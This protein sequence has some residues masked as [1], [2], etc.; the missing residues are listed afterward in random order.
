ML[1]AAAVLLGGA[2]GEADGAE[3]LV[4]LDFEDAADLRL[5]RSRH[6]TGVSDAISSRGRSS[7]RVRT[8]DTLNVVTPRLGGARP[9]DLLKLD[10][11]NATAAPRQVRVEL[12]DAQSAKGYWHR[13]VRRYALRP[14]WNT[15]RF[16][17][18]RLYRGEKN[19]R[20][21]HDTY[22]DPSHI[23]RLDLSLAAG[24]E[25]GSVYLDNLRFE[26]D[27]PMPPVDGLLAFD[28]GPENQAPR[29]GFIACSRERY[30][31]DR[32]YGWKTS[33]WP[34]AVRD[35]VHP[36]DLLGDVREAR[37]DTFSVRV[38]NGTYHVRVYYEDHGWWSD[39]FARFSRRTL[40]AEGKPAYEESRTRRQAAERFCRFADLEP[41]PETD[42]YDT[43]IRNGRYA[44]K[45]FDVRVR[46][47]RLDLAF[48][49]DA[50]WACRI[51]ALVLWPTAS[52]EAA[53]EWCAELDRRLHDAFDAEHV[54]ID[55]APRGHRQADL[56]DGAAAGGLLV[57]SAGP[58]TPM[59]PGTI[60]AEDELLSEI[61]LACVPGEDT[62]T[63]FGLRAAAAGGRAVL[64]ARLEGVDA[65]LY[66]VQNRIRRHGG[67]YTLTPDI[68]RRVDAL[69]L[70][71]GRTRQFWLEVRV[72]PG[73]KPGRYAGEV[74]VAFDGQTRT[75]PVAVAVLP[76]VL[77]EPRT[78][79]GMFG[80]LPDCHAP[81]GAL[82]AVAELLR[83]HGMSSA[84]GLPMGRVRAENG[85]L[86]VDFT[87]A[88]EAM[89]ALRKAGFTLPVDT[90]GGGLR[91]VAAAADKL[92]IPH[93]D[94]LRQAM[95]H[96]RQH[97]ELM[98]WLPVTYSMVDEPQWSDDAVARAAGRVRRMHRA[99]P[100]VLT[101]GYWNPKPD[102]PAHRELMD[103]LG[104]TTMNRPTPEAVRA[105]RSMGKSIGLYG[106]C[107]RHD[108]GL[109]Q[110][111]AAAEGFEA[112]YAWHFY[113]RY[114]D[115]Y[116]DLDGREPDV[117]MVYYTPTEVRP[118][119]R[120]KAVRAGAY[121]FR[122][123]RTLADLLEQRQTGATADAARALLE[124][125]E[126]A[127]NLYRERSAPVIADYDT[128]RH[129]VVEAIL[130]LQ[131]RIQE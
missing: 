84:S 103:A 105:L 94:A 85:S 16:N 66:L 21:I 126:A 29:V 5:V 119:L 128:F 44:P 91:G 87:R 72:P 70:D 62:G 49:A 23:G 75:I 53:A 89:A 39:Q 58:T 55:T 34:G 51:A 82:E 50:P 56:P 7:L 90:Y 77:S 113:I 117:C 76:I 83:R 81:P 30:D 88:D 4:V 10:L 64:D 47:E 26:P 101:N 73:T 33:G 12:F 2:Q 120:L 102:H 118:S 71:A 8:G 74:T 13:H 111:A 114:G 63:A 79:F 61:T 57:F 104:R 22:L 95:T 107:T 97:A 31:P 131:R 130:G 59:P 48:G 124:R 46:D 127:G 123:L 112:H 6:G 106:G 69:A 98:D 60:P 110:W 1:L 35:F 11:F 116:Y 78:A 28:F 20:R 122:Y 43:Y 100:W 96:T 45:E 125:A 42:V 37:D 86:R 9:G 27:P 36:N 15:L 32:G 93:E 24:G 40:T 68:L 38:P 80:L 52:T 67:G 41:E 109:R 92:G 65:E 121:D 99:A 108:F 54:Y 115:L 17:V 14:G 18:A 3:P 129:E 19:A 25:A